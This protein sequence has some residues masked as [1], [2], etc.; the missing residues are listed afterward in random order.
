MSLVQQLVKKGVLEK[1]R[2]TPLEYEIKTSGKREEEVIL[3]KKIVSELRMARR[4]LKI[5][6]RFPH[7]AFRMLDQHDQVWA[8]VCNLMLGE[9]DYTTIKVRTSGFKGIY[10]LLFR[11]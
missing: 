1:A 3:E 6:V 10:N 9:I 7:L 4:L 11:I 5:L 2:A 8:T